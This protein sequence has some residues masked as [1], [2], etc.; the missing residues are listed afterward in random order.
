MMKRLRPVRGGAL[1]RCKGDAVD[2]IYRELK[3]LILQDELRPGQRL[4]AQDLAGRFHVSRTPVAQAL[5]RLEQEGYAVGRPNRG[6]Q[7]AEVE[8]GEAEE[9][10]GLREAL[11]V[12][13]G[14]QAAQ[15][16]HSPA[17]LLRLQGRMRN[18]AQLKG[19]P[20]LSRRKLLL[21]FAF[22]MAIA[23]MAGNAKVCEVLSRTFER[24]I[25]KRKIEGVPSR[26][27]LTVRE[28]Q[29]I[30]NAIAKHDATGA[31]ALLRQHIQNSR[32]NLLHY[33]RVK[34]ALFKLDTPG[35][36]VDEVSL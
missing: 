2:R 22:H 13:A 3:E 21:D 19:E 31:V 7:I 17:A 27:I 5:I 10:F 26:G 23:E 18:Y 24:L 20:V 34:E 32:A 11:E 16:S 4:V 35:I 12:Y 28:H 8:P 33:L 25:M 36:P 1:R 15:A 9:L 30:Y 14:A 29:A 6:F